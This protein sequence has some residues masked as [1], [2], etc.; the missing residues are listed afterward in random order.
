MTR[1]SSNR[2]AQASSGELNGILSRCEQ[3][4]DFRVVAYYCPSQL[5]VL[6]LFLEG[7][8]WSRFRAS[9][10]A[11][12]HTCMRHNMTLTKIVK[13]RNRTTTRG[14]V[15]SSFAVCRQRLRFAVPR[16]SVRTQGDQASSNVGEATVTSY[17]RTWSLSDRVI[18]QPAR[19]L[20]SFLLHERDN[21]LG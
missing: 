18:F 19:A 16:F 1:R 10:A 4:E 17:R 3:L 11:L 14:S 12:R 15:E 5:T 7:G 2:G 9:P 8:L 20:N 6:S 13:T 21:E